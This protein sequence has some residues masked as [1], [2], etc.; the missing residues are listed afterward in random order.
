MTPGRRGSH[1]CPSRKVYPAC[2][3]LDEQGFVE[4][5][6][7]KAPEIV[8]GLSLEAPNPRF[9]ERVRIWCQERRPDSTHAGTV[10]QT[11]KSSRELGVAIMDE[12]PY[13]ELL[14]L[15]PHHHLS[16]LWPNPP[17][18]WMICGRAEKHLRVP[19]WMNAAMPITPAARPTQGKHL[20]GSTPR[21]AT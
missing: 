5:P 6:Q 9:R 11:T 13:V 16:P 17:I 2:F 10:E 15:E 14:V 1:H 7:A 20:R 19:T 4:V 18:V 21:G 12:E 8:R 3:A